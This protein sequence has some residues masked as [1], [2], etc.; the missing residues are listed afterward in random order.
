MAVGGPTDRDEAE[1]RELAR[2]HVWTGLRTPQEQ[3]EAMVAAVGV[4]MPHTDPQVMA[5]AWLVA[6]QREHARA[7][8]GWPTPTDHDRL[9]AALA[10]CRSRDVLVLPGEDDLARVRGA[11][12]A[13]GRLL[14][15]VLWF[16]E[17]AVWRAVTDSEL[18]LWLRHGT[19]VPAVEGDPLATAVVACLGRHGLQAR[20]HEDRVVA[21]VRWQRRLGASATG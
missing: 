18:E 9:T 13:A 20:W 8:Q 12:E 14:R 7:A 3:L 19:G 1:L 21:A 11:V 10:E 6:A 16:G 2:L 5:R 17:Q 15:G 4:Q